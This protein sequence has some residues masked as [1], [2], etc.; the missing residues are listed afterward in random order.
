MHPEDSLTTVAATL[1]RQLRVDAAS[2]FERYGKLSA[3]IMKRSMDIA[4]SVCALILTAPLFLVIA[5]VIKLTSTGPILFR[6]E[7]A[8]WAGRRFVM[9]KFRTMYVASD[10]TIHEQYIERWIEG[11]IGPRDASDA[12]VYKLSNDPRVTPFGRLLRRTSLDEL[13]QFFNV[14]T[15]AMSLVGPRPPIP[16]EVGRYS[17]WHLQRL[18]VRPGITGLWQVNGRNRLTFDDMVRLDITYARSWSLWLDLKILCRTPWVVV[19]DRGA[20]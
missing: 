16:Y 1:P 9:L 20:C 11:T 15:G 3:R 6:Q 17:A 19:S 8:G 14:L 12:P 2:G 4:G 18:A 10:S 5:L 13:P 7:R